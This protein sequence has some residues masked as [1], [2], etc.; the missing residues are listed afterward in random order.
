VAKLKKFNY[1][2]VYAYIYTFWWLPNTMTKRKFML[3]SGDI[4]SNVCHV[5]FLFVNLDDDQIFEHALFMHAAIRVHCWTLRIYFASN[6]IFYRRLLE[7]CTSDIWCLSTHAT[8][9][10]QY[11]DVLFD[12]WV[13]MREKMSFDRSNSNFQQFLINISNYRRLRN[14]KIDILVSIHTSYSHAY[15]IILRFIM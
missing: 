3:H 13:Q 12:L 2:Y 4:F 14:N 8:M 9:Q 15:W 5:H 1:L 11:C 7:A 10:P 6:E